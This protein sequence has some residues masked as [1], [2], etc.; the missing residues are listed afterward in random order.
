MVVSPAYVDA[1]LVGS[2]DLL[3][4]ATIDCGHQVYLEAEAETGRLVR[5]HLAL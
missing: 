1:C 4:V 2:G 3:T 5:Q